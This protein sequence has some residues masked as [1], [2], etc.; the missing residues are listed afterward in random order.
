MEHG[1]TWHVIKNQSWGKCVFAELSPG[2]MLW[3]I[4]MDRAPV[5]ISVRILPDEPYHRLLD[6]TRLPIITLDGEEI[7]DFNKAKE[8]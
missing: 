4:G 7:Q 6:T 8:T 1:H 2:I 5:Y 3:F